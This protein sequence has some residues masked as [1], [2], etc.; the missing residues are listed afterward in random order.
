MGDSVSLQSFYLILND[1]V[2]KSRGLNE[3]NKLKML[4]EE[5]CVEEFFK[6]HSDLK[7]LFE[8]MNTPHRVVFLSMVF[9]R[10]AERV[11]VAFSNT[12]EEVKKVFAL[13]DTLEHVDSFYN[14]IGGIIGYHAKTLE[15]ILEKQNQFIKPTKKTFF[16]RAQGLDIVKDPKVCDKAVIEGLKKLELMAEIYPIGGA[17][18]RLGLISDEGVPLPAAVLPFLNATLLEGLI[19][20]LQAREYLYFKLFSK[21]CLTPIALMTS[22][23]KDNY[24]FI[25]KICEK[26][27]WFGRG[28]ENFRIF[29]Q[30]LVPVVTLNGNWKLKNPFDVTFKPGG[31]GMLWKL[32]EEEK[33]FDWLR[34]K[35]RKKGLIR[36]INNPLAGL[37]QAILAFSGFGLAKDKGFGFLSCQRL[38]GAAEGVLVLAQEQKDHQYDYRIT[39]LE[40]TDF[41][42]YGFK[43][44]AESKDDNYSIYPSNTNILFFDIDKVESIIPKEPIPGLLVNIKNEQEFDPLEATFKEIGCARLES[45]MQNIADS[46]TNTFDVE[47]QQNETEEKLDTFIVYNDRAKTISVTKRSYFPGKSHLE[48]PVGCYFDLI[49]ANLLLLKDECSFE[50]IT[51]Q[52]VE[53][54][55]AIGPNQIFHYNPALGPL[56]SIIKNK[57]RK[58]YFGSNAELQLN[59]AEA[60]ILDLHLEGSLIVESKNPLGILE[61]FSS[62][63]HGGAKIELI[64]V[65]I[66]NKGRSSNQSEEVWK[67]NFHRNESLKITLFEG[68]EFF[69]QDI[70]FEGSFDITV[71]KWQRAIAKEVNGQVVIE[72]QDISKPTW[73]WKY[74]LIDEQIVI[75]KIA[76]IEP[77]C[78]LV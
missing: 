25:R 60:D 1:F 68:S 17:G 41:E 67:N 43:D 16:R 51:F 33:I 32:A 38:V 34:K 66:K 64:G 78:L 13:V 70:T 30:P 3:I 54:Y 9:L 74:D 8:S 46:L 6:K 45:T 65:T 37:D 28:E 10:Q 22:Y 69:A 21:Q 27:N 75:K 19:K 11:F 55:L 20:D 63:S 73:Y 58:G 44:V 56:Y 14:G 72:Y 47:L 77:D 36:Q 26:N 52:T 15:L 76:A 48:T 7:K 39:N 49:N 31:H 71:P 57:V 5:V 29:I 59:I 35:G 12:Q 50:G 24:L 61:G 18:D 42:R 2:E 62:Y 23:E 4:L 53:D 40:Y